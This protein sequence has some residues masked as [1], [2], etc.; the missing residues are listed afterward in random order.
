MSVYFSDFFGVKAEKIEK[1]G[2]FNISL[3]NDIP[4]FI[5]PFLLFSSEKEEYKKLHDNII[6][7]VTFLKDKSKNDPSDPINEGSRQHW[8]FFPEVKQSWLGFCKKGNAGSG[9]G[10]SFATSLSRNLATT[11]TNFGSEEITASSHLEKLCLINDGVGKDHISDFTANLIKGFL[12]EYTQEFSKKYINKAYLKE[13]NV[14]HAKFNYE[15]CHWE[16]KS[17]TLPYIDGDYVLLTPKDI[18]TKDEGWINKHDIIGDF[19]NII[20]SMPNKVLRGQINQYLLRNIPSRRTQTEINRVR[21]KAVIKFPALIDYYIKLK[22]DTGKKAVSI[23]SQKIRETEEIFN[24]H[25]TELIN[26]LK[27]EDKFYNIKADTHDEAYKRLLYLKQ[28]IENNDGYK[29]FYSK[30]VPVKKESD[31]QLM[32][33]L[34]WYASQDDVN[35]EVNN[36]RGP[37]DYKISRGANDKTLVEFKLASN[38]KLKQNLNTQVE[39]YQAANTTK[40]AIK[41]IIYFSTYELDRV[42]KIL[43]ELKLQEGKNLVLID[44]RNSNKPSAS[45]AK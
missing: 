16:N 7:Y 21:T 28:V 25:V 33:R 42:E 44:A 4:V 3:I 5:D 20:S 39:V 11:F 43:K 37:V 10:Q 35:S 45:N 1:Y 6:K 12:C 8:F 14:S 26:K 29:L 19:N 9:L 15:L 18:L 36:G 32:F 17:Y 2:A 40:K 31:L 22:E 30:N 13:N 41:V 34:T 23:S 38:S 24:R 27:E